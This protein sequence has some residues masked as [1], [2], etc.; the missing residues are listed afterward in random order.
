MVQAT[1]DYAIN[2][3][4]WSLLSQAFLLVHWCKDPTNHIYMQHID[5]KTLACVLIFHFL[6]RRAP[7]Q[8]EVVHQMQERTPQKDLHRYYE[9]L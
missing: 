8:F 5:R 2:I 3:P 6:G 4:D 1:L 7:M 9:R